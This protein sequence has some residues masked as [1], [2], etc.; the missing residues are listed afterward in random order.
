M[1]TKRSRPMSLLLIAAAIVTLAITLAA[2]VAS[3]P[4]REAYQLFYFL[5][6]I[7]AFMCL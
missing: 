3:E 6:G 1:P 4:V 7:A 2:A 5:E